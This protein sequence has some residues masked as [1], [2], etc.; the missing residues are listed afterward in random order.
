MNEQKPEKVQSDL[1]SKAQRFGAFGWLAFIVT[2]VI[3][4]TQNLVYSLKPVPMYA[5]ENGKVIGQVLFDEAKIRSISDIQKDLKTFIQNCTSVNKHTIYEDLSIC[6]NHMNEQLA[7]TYLTQYE[8]TN[9]PAKIENLGCEVTSI[10]FDENKTN[11][12]R[13]SDN[14]AS[15][16]ISGD[17]ICSINGKPQKQAFK[18]KVN[19]ILTLRNSDRPLG[20]EVT[21]FEDI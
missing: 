4:L 18:S 20:I 1:I 11:I 12:Q 16:I 15:G 7:S 9:Y 17:V 2:L 6:I 19:A 13:T 5:V 14:T 21:K 3:L 10:E 8:E